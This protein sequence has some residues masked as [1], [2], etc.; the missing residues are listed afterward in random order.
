MPNYKV[1]TKIFDFCGGPPT[2]AND[3]PPLAKEARKAKVL[4][5]SILTRRSSFLFEASVWLHD[6]VTLGKLRLQ[7]GLLKYSALKKKTKLNCQRDEK[8]FKPQIKPL[9][10]RQRE[11][12]IF[13]KVCRC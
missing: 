7:A 9:R 2:L 13:I 6:A 4:L 5:G 11:R 8:T 3:F 1:S 12:T 10:E